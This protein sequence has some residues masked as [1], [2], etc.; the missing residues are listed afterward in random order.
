MVI[1]SIP[2]NS[3]VCLGRSA[4]RRRQRTALLTNA[5]SGLSSLVH[6][7]TAA[8]PNHNIFLIGGIS[9]QGQEFVDIG[10]IEAPHKLP[11]VVATASSI[12][13]C[14]DFSEFHLEW[15]PVVANSNNRIF[16]L[17]L[18]ADTLHGLTN[19]QL[20]RFGALHLF[21][22]GHDTNFPMVQ[23]PFL[24]QAKSAFCFWDPR[25]PR[26]DLGL[27]FEFDADSAAA[28]RTGIQ[29]VV[30][31]FLTD[32]GLNGSHR[33]AV[34]DAVQR[35]IESHQQK[36]VSKRAL[37][38][39]HDIP[40][41]VLKGVRLIRC[42]PHGAVDTGALLDSK[43]RFYPRPENVHQITLSDIQKDEERFDLTATD[44]PANDNAAVPH[45]AAASAVEPVLGELGVVNADAQLL[46]RRRRR[47][48]GH[49]WETHPHGGKKPKTRKKVCLLLGM[50]KAVC[51]QNFHTTQ[52]A[53][54]VIAQM[55][56]DGA[57]TEMDGRDLVRIKATELENNVSCYTVS[58]QQGA[59]Y[60]EQSHVYG[61]FNR[62]GFLREMKMKQQEN[63]P[64]D[65]KPLSFT[66]I[67][68]DYYWLP[69]G[70][71]QIHWTPSL[72][73][74][75][76]PTF[77]KEKLIDLDD[78]PEH[79]CGI[80]L[81]FCFRTIQ[82]LVKAYGKLKKLFAIFFV[83]KADLPKLTLWSG[84]NCIDANMMQH[85][86][87]KRRDQEE[88]YCGVSLNEVMESTQT[89]VRREDLLAVLNLLD[90]IAEIR[91]IRLLPIYCRHASKD[92]EGG[93]KGLAAR[94]EDV[95]NGISAAS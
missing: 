25:D 57:L 8:W 87:G 50:S 49:T 85:T 19:Q 26:N 67:I 38:E 21:S 76:L 11:P 75:V 36:V 40:K 10:L 5:W 14:H 31:R 16:T 15:R 27:G 42:F 44:L 22:I 54:K 20:E 74:T 94:T 29:Q 24:G 39:R 77:A 9:E 18:V 55:V 62:I 90:D 28:N 81:P 7:I 91:Y 71:L 56:E 69:S 17:S 78:S 89:H 60:E 61:N 73:E 65:N 46:P 3:I 37:V 66:Q 48:R 23:E 51:S 32:H 30:S 68:W 58:M 34:R 72:F 33:R 64:H 2:P 95:T 53:C 4:I 80:Y 86:F 41:S 63:F 92:K 70:W 52:E 45:T 6:R 13:T 93:W 35:G 1:A 84:T 82:G 43:P 88:R 79:P 83:R 59:E 12:E 47:P